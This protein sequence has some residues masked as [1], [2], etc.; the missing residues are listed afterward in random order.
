V[1]SSS[2]ARALA[3]QRSPVAVSATLVLAESMVPAA[4]SALAA[5]RRL[6]QRGQSESRYSFE[7]Y[8]GDGP[9][10]ECELDSAR[11]I[12]YFRY[13]EWPDNSSQR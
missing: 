5:N 2:S 4:L 1:Q 11:H 3:R 8:A 9:E 12:L 6:H 10:I 13:A 7:S